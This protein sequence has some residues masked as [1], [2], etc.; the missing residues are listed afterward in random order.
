MADEVE[1]L[2]AS[3]LSPL[4]ENKLKE[5]LGKKDLSKVYRVRYVD[6]ANHECRF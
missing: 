4:T 3:Q 5:L 2:F 6:G 1:S